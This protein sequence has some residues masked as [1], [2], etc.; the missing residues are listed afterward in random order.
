[1]ASLAAGRGL[2][3]AFG[4][5]G[6]VSALAKLDAAVPEWSTSRFAE[7]NAPQRSVFIHIG[8]LSD[9]NGAQERSKVRFAT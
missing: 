8:W 6:P 5:S 1:M 7:V 3:H 4:A 2:A 9:I